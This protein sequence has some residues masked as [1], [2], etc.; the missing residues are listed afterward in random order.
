MFL[1]AVEWTVCSIG[2]GVGWLI[3]GE[4]MAAGEWLQVLP[5]NTIQ[6]SC[7]DEGHR[8]YVE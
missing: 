2:L 5:N 1:N 6:I 7:V 3:Y 8:L 4:V